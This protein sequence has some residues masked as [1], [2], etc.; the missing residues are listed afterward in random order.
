MYSNKSKNYT[1]LVFKIVLQRGR[2]GHSGDRG[3]RGH[4]HHHRSR[5]HGAASS[6]R[7]YNSSNMNNY[8]SPPPYT[9]RSQPYSAKREYCT[10][11][12]GARS[13]RLLF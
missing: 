7:N 13:I 3:Y 4:D 6:S 5:Q 10:Y 11:C 8:Q 9:S 2:R 12:L 1:N